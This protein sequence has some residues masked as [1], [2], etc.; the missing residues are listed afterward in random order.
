[1]DNLLRTAAERG[2]RFLE[3]INDRPV[4]PHPDAVA[5]LQEL[6]G[7]LPDDPS[8]PVEVITLLDEIG[9]PA[10]MANA[11]G[12][13]FGY[14]IG[15]SMPAATAANLLAGAWNQNAGIRKTSPVATALEEIALEWL[16]DVLSLPPGTGAGF[17]TG[18]TMANFAGLAAARHILLKRLGWDVENQGLYGAPEITIV[19]GGEVHVS[20]LKA[21]SLLGLGRERVVRVPVDG[22]GRM[23]ADAL[24]EL[25]DTTIVCI[26]AGNVDTGAFDP[27]EEII[28]LA[29]D[30]GAWV[31]VD[32]AFGLWA[33]AAP[34]RAHLVAGF[35]DADSWATDGHKWLNVPYDCGIIFCRNP[36]YLLSAMT[37]LPSAYITA[38]QPRERM[39]FTPELSRRA[40]GIEVWAV[41][42]TLGRSGL[43]D[44]VE[45]MCRHAERFAEG[46][47]G[48]GYDILNDVVIN[49][50][51]VS[52]GNADVTNRVIAGIQSDGTCWCSG[53]TW[54]GHT[55]MRI[56][57]S[58]WATT[59]EDVERSLEAMLRIAKQ[60]A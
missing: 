15:S 49:Q 47:S 42:R 59:E 34:K 20:L 32:G 19:V 3:G 43:A 14:V 48:A 28:P 2:I 24:P 5:R 22:Q 52:F 33:A 35:A 10:T 9:S 37:P 53:T 55:A 21:L 31:H 50:V 60:N 41:L 40:R 30:A 7:A 39:Y 18:T 26:Q 58:G 12:R 51:L 16:L 56:S 8:D 1:M 45:R 44:M 13:Y 4:A 54:H 57:V 29:H 38:D 6:G 11:G 46:L 25:T 36:D 17:V 23:R 27:A